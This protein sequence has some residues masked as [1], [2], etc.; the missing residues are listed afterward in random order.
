MT[1]EL[2]IALGIVLFAIIAMLIIAIFAL[3]IY[4]CVWVGV[5]AEYYEANRREREANVILIR[6][7]RIYRPNNRKRRGKI[8]D[9]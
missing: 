6:R 7:D 2:L 8:K 5:K 9:E 1:K 3:A 4:A